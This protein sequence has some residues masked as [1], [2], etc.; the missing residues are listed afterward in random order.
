VFKY[1]ENVCISRKKNFLLAW[2]FCETVINN[3]GGVGNGDGEHL[4]GI[5]CISEFT[6]L[7][8]DQGFPVVSQFQLIES[9]YSL[10][11]PKLT[12]SW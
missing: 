4:R 12:C 10:S 8:P 9:H 5:F 2:E 11:H 7:T 6:H 1:G 3:K